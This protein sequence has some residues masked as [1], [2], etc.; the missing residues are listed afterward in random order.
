VV[1]GVIMRTGRFAV[2]SGMMAAC[3]PDF[4][5]PVVEGRPRGATTQV[6]NK[7]WSTVPRAG[8][9]MGACVAGAGDVNGDGFGDVIIAAADHLEGVAVYYGSALGLASVPDWRQDASGL[10]GAGTCVA[11]AGDVNGDDFDDIVIGQTE[12]DADPDADPLN[13][14]RASLVLGSATGLETAPAWVTVAKSDRAEYGHAVGAAGDVNGDGYDDIVVAA[15][16]QSTGEDGIHEGQVFVYHGSATGLGTSSA[17][18]MS[19]PDP[20]FHDNQQFGY[21]VASAGDVDGDGF[22]DVAIGWKDFPNTQRPQGKVVVYRGSASGLEIVPAWTWVGPVE[23]WETGEVHSVASA[24]DVNGDG[25]SDLLVGMPL[26]G[27]LRGSALLFHGSAA[28]L[29]TDPAWV[30]TTAAGDWS[31]GS[32]VAAAGDVNA[33]GYADVIVGAPDAP[34]A[35]L[36]NGM[37][38]LYLGS[39]AGLSLSHVWSGSTNREDTSPNESARARYG[40]SVASAGDVDGDGFGDVIVGATGHMGSTYGETLPGV[41]LYSGG[42]F[43]RDGDGVPWEVDICPEAFD[44]SQVDVN[45]DGVGDAC[46][47]LDL[48]LAEVSVAQGVTIE[49]DGVAPGETV[50]VALAGRLTGVGPCFPGLAGLCLDL[51]VDALHFEAVADATGHATL[52]GAALPPVEGLV[53]GTFVTVQ[54]AAPAPSGGGVK[55]EPVEVLVAP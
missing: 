34:L 14:G 46:V 43:D 44:P 30:R 29:E 15:P 27:D 4:G 45:G 38:Y 35:G 32:S 37:A 36:E 51:A 10:S 52:V 31:Y 7:A 47:P 18:T 54:A 17:W 3:A 40:H 13:T 8:I 55:S 53:A 2:F 23:P 5:A 26:I 49:V 28:G 1:P 41:F 20:Y 39:P 48:A 33:D 25:Y 11:P 50:R 6:L 21:A 9:D 19:P 24:G 12:F 42:I 22:D 16:N